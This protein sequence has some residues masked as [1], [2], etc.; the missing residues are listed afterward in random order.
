MEHY[1]GIEECFITEQKYEELKNKYSDEHL[2][3]KIDYLKA[4]IESI[5][6]YIS[7]CINKNCEPSESKFILSSIEDDLKELLEKEKNE[8]LICLYIPYYHSTKLIN[9]T[10]E[11]AEY[12]DEYTLLDSEA[13]ELLIKENITIEPVPEINIRPL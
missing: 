1:I 5:K 2:Y 6:E 12:E 11:G 9:V 4:N 10:E 3:R 8:K 13:K 7:R